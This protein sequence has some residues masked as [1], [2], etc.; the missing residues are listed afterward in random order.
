[1]LEGRFQPYRVEDISPKLISADTDM[2]QGDWHRTFRIMTSNSPGAH[3]ACGILMFQMYR[4][5]QVGS[6]GF[7]PL[8][9]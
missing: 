5:V 4:P 7:Q 8:H 3:N 6:R 1:M 2:P 9:N